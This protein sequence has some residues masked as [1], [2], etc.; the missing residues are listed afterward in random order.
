MFN[1]VSKITQESSNSSISSMSTHSSPTFEVVETEINFSNKP[2]TIS[3]PEKDFSVLC[4]D[5]FNL[6]GLKANGFDLLD[7]V[8]DHHCGYCNDMLNGPTYTK[9]VNNFWVRA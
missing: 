8:L 6:H 3:T 5:I 4:E 9:V 7:V 2:K 1:S